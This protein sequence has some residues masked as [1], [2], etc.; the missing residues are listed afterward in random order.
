MAR[1]LH[2]NGFTL[3]ELMATM[4]IGS[5]ILLCAATLLSQAGTGY[6]RGSAGIAAER[7]GRAALTIM[8][9]DLSKAVWHADTKV[10]SQGTKWVNGKLGIL[11]L[12]ADDAQTKGERVGDLCGIYYYLQDQ[13]IGTSTVRCLMRGFNS[14]AQTF[15]SLRVSG[16]ADLFEGKEDDE[17]IAFGV[18]SFEATLVKRSSNGT[19]EDWQSDGSSTDADTNR[20]D[21]V[22]IRLA[23]A[24]REL[25]A[26]LKTKDDWDRGP[27]QDN[28]ND[29]FLNR[30]LEVY[31]IVQRFGNND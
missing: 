20:P 28:P 10:E 27:L 13:Q 24:R 25:A 18:V 16:I 15:S 17:P 30:D 23:I 26:K 12:Q 29:P 14:S 2:R 21:A 5:M 1:S 9:E 6:D 19:W 8:S 7:E 31:E 22:K 4:T 11:S 3:V